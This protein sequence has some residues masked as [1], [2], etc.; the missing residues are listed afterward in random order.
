[1]AS[2]TTTTTTPVA[3]PIPPTPLDPPYPRGVWARVLGGAAFLGAAIL[4]GCGGA[5]ASGGGAPR[6]G[7]AQSAGGDDPGDGSGLIVA[8]T[9]APFDEVVGAAEE[10]IVS[11]D[12]TLMTRV[13][14][15]ANA[16]GAGLELRPT[17]LFIFGK[18]QAGTPLMVDA[19]TIAIDLPQKLLVVADQESGTVRVVVNDPVH[20]AH[21]HGLDGEDP[22]IQRLAGVLRAIAEDAA[23]P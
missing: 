22:R 21:R 13:D 23:N 4:I 16:S 8:E 20:L 3:A 5:P 2:R 9:Q 6:T 14:H 12:L 17:T 18:P 10:A 19:P 1:M 7:T 11:R 15:R